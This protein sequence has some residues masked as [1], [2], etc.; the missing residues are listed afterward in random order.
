MTNANKPVIK[1]AH[2]KRTLGSTKKFDDSF[3][4]LVDESFTKIVD[5]ISNEVLISQLEKI[6]ELDDRRVL[7]DIRHQH[8]NYDAVLDSLRGRL[9]T[10]QFHQAKNAI[11]N[12]LEGALIKRMMKLAFSQR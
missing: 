6:E 9:E 12:R 5:S 1:P 2:T 4:A 7:G 3:Q 11:A 8:S 10:K